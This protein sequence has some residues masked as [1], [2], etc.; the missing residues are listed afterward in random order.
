MPRRSESDRAPDPDEVVVI[1]HPPT[2]QSSTCRRKALPTW[3]RSGWLEGPFPAAE[4]E[5][6]QDPEE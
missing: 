4:A 5:D 3:E 2:G 6:A 1:H